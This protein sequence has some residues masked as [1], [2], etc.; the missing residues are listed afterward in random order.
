[1]GRIQLVF[2]T[3]PVI[4]LALGLKMLFCMCVVVAS[5]TTRIADWAETT[6]RW[7]WTRHA[8]RTTCKTVESHCQYCNAPVLDGTAGNHIYGTQY[9]STDP[10]HQRTHNIMLR[11]PILFL[12]ST[13]CLL[14]VLLLFPLVIEWVSWIINGLIRGKKDWKL[15]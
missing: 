11:D 3:A 8:A 6:A 4:C 10:I 13:V 12:I 2:F 15:P 1:M 9:L 14:T 5:G 7:I